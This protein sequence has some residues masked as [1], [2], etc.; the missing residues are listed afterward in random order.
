MSEYQRYEFMTIDRSLTPQQLK[1]VND[2]SSHIEASSTHA[3]IEYH[4]GDFKHDPIRVLHDYFDGFLYWA[5]WGSPQFALRFPHGALSADLLKSYDLE[6]E[7]VTFTEHADYDILDIHFNEMEAL[8]EWVDYE[9]GPLMPIRDELMAGDMRALYII[10]LA[11]QEWL[12]GYEDEDEEVSEEEDKTIRGPGVPPGLGTLTAAQEALAELFRVSLDLTVAAARYSSPITPMPDDDIVAWV[13]LLPQQR[14]SEY[15]VRLAQNEL[16]LSR[17]LLN[18]LRELGR[19]KTEVQP[20]GKYVSYS[21]LLDE[22]KAIHARLTRER[23]E[24]E[25]QARQRHLQSVINQQETYWKR[26]DEAV[27]RKNSAGYDEA[28]HLLLDLRD[29]SDHFHV[30]PQFQD[31]FRAW[32]RAYINRPAMIRRLR[33][34]GFDF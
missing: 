4:W 11:V 12:G 14:R 26:I 10:W 15:L 31:R 27:G 34:S 30:R 2:L 3:S 28:H 24:Q 7:F 22:R 1:E 33:E 8:D 5:N 20:Q 9:L 25:Q 13:E 32:V 18:E 21:T 16:G 17:Q 19:G 23:L 6:E 29:A